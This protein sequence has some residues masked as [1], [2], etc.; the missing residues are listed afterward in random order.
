MSKKQTGRS[1]KPD[2]SSESSGQGGFA[3]ALVLLALVGMSTMAMAGYLRSNTDYK[4]NQNHRAATR[5]FYVTDAGR[6]QHI[7]KARIS[8]DTTTYSY[9]SGSVDV[10]AEPLGEEPRSG[11]LDRPSSA[12]SRLRA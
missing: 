8:S 4:I 6:G 3:L 10:W 7:A 1:Q 9:S 11:G 2:Q 5:A 12:L